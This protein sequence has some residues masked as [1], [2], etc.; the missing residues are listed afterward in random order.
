MVW[1]EFTSLVPAESGVISRQ[2]RTFPVLTN[3]FNAW[4]IPWMTDNTT[5]YLNNSPTFKLCGIQ[6]NS[7]PASEL[8][9]SHSSPQEQAL[10]ASKSQVAKWE[11]RS[12]PAKNIREGWYVLRSQFKCRI[13]SGCSH[14]QPYS[15]K[16]SGKTHGLQQ[17]V[18]QICAV[19]PKEEAPDK[20]VTGSR[21]ST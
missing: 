1:A 9:N 13:D 20:D 5:L 4:L 14:P 2:S 21:M 10:I 12:V 18:P 3:I 7:P 6:V 16:D 15:L 8:F 17:L 11:P 19:F